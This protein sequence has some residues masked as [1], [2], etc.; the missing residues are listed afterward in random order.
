VEVVVEGGSKKDPSAD[1][2]KLGGRVWLSR[3]GLTK[4]Y[5]S[6]FFCFGSPV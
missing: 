5:C 4:P 1:R 6:G 3:F 2:R